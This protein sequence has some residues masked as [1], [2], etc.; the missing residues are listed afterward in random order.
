[1]GGREESSEVA[2]EAVEQ[3][4]VA[5]MPVKKAR[6]NRTSVMCLYQPMKLGTRVVVQAQILSVFKMFLN[7]PSGANGLD[8]LWQGG[9]FRGKDARST[10]SR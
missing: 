9:S 10:L 1:M 6:A 7:M 4:S 3:G 5:Q 2:A 8:H